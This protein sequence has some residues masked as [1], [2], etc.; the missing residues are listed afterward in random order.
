MSPQTNNMIYEV[1][2]RLTESLAHTNPSNTYVFPLNHFFC[3]ILQLCKRCI[4][5]DIECFRLLEIIFGFI[6]KDPTKY[7]FYDTHGLSKSNGV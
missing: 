1:I 5:T 7:R 6:R 3:L 2:P 4:E